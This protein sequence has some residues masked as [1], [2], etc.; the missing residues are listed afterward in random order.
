MKRPA[1]LGT[2]QVHDTHRLIKDGFVFAPGVIEG[3]T[4]RAWLTDRR[5]EQIARVCLV[6]ACL[7]T[8]FAT[9]AFVSGFIAL[10]GLL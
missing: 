4:R 8:L 1:H 9:L 10:K 5:F 7:V 3:P 2:G 6:L